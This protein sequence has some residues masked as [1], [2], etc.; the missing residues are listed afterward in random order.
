MSLVDELKK[1]LRETTIEWVVET[2]NQNVPFYEN[3]DS[4]EKRTVR[5]VTKYAKLGIPIK[6]IGDILLVESMGYDYE[7]LAKESECQ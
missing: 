2:K 7:A 4:L 1:E 5:L 3:Q 6:E